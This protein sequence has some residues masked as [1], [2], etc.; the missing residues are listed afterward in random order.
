MS[1]YY[2]AKDIMSTPTAIIVAE[3]GSA[4][5]PFVSMA[6]SGGRDVLVVEQSSVE[7]ASE[8][9]RRVRETL[10]ELEQSG[11]ALRGAILV[12]GG[13]TDESVLSARSS[14]VRTLIGPMVHADEGEMVLVS[15]GRDRFSMQGLA[16]V[17]AEML[18]G[19]NVRVRS[20]SADAGVKAA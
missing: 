15:S 5:G 13:R 18:R 17:T 10:E 20:A 12:G 7:S 11:A 4:F 6:R 14:M 8:L 16:A 9:A 3:H 19:A 2:L 1:A